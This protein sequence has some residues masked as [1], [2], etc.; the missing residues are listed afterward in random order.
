[1]GLFSLFTYKSKNGKKYWLHMKERHNV[2]LYYLS[3]NP[4]GALQNLPKGYIVFENPRTHMPML[5]KGKSGFLSNILGSKP[6]E[7]KEEP[8]KENKEKKK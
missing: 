2:K 8:K 5:K 1:M 7:N 4:L 6:S 3:K